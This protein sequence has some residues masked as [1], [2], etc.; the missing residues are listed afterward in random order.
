M[1]VPRPASLGR[2]GLG[3]APAP[4]RVGLGG[5]RRAGRPRGRL[6]GEIG[7]ARVGS[8]ATE[9]KFDIWDG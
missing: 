5:A 2:A 9:R 4:P 8:A 7:S 3:G 1:R 6:A